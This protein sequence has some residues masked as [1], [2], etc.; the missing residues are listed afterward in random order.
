MDK[1]RNYVV[2]SPV[3]NEEKHLA[4]TIN[5]MVAQTIR[6]LSWV[7]VN[8]GSRDDTGRIAEQATDANPWI[9]V[10][11]R[12]DRGF[13][14]AGGG[15]VEAFYEGYRLI[16]NLS[17]D[18]VVKLDGD[19]SFAPDYFEQCFI[20]F[21]RDERLGI[22]GGTICCRVGEIIEP[23]A[24]AD[25]RFHVRGATK[26]Y[27]STCWHRIGGLIAAP[28]WDTLDEIKA[29]MLG[30]ATYTLSD[31]KVL[32]HRPTGAAYGTWNDRVKNGMANY[33]SG[34]H[35]LFMLL[36]CARR[37]TAEP[38]VVGGL[39][40]LF[41]FVKGYLKRIPQVEDRALIG[42]LRQQQMNR[43]LGRKSLWN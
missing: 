22:G 12:P 13:R 24:K 10:V 11:N 15:V 34:Y 33:V 35:P 18:Y 19:L 36:K 20:E 21:E 3:R 29:N 32:H 40:L 30:W 2:V 27:R 25:P 28:G 39:G 23:E 1:T 42:Y 6:P 26:I 16:E 41:G 5:S 43:L 14:Q 9:K 38:Y 7:I 8:D 31:V 37:M 4:L 17:W